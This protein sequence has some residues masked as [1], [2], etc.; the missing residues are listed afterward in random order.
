MRRPVHAGGYDRPAANATVKAPLSMIHVMFPQPIDVKSAGFAVT[1]DGKPIDVGK[2][3]R[4]VR[5]AR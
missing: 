2:R 3:C 4:W 5:T 1:K